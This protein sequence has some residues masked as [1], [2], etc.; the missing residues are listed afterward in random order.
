M[1]KS[2]FF[3]CIAVAACLTACKS[4]MIYSTRTA[5]TAEMPVETWNQWTTADLQVAADKVRVT[6]EAS[7]N[8]KLIQTEAQLKESAI[9]LALEKHNADILINPLFTCEY[10]DGKLV[11]VT[12]SGYPAKHVNFRSISFEEQT[13]YMVEKAKAEHAAQ[14]VINGGEIKNEVAAPAPLPAPQEEPAKVQKAKK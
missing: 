9:G 7:Q 3:A 11:R 1:K 5:R 12:V 10:A 13:H 8:D 2:F 6:V 14:I 4:P